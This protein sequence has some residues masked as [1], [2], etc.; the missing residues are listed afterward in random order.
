MLIVYFAQ[1]P[2][3]EEISR[4]QQLLTDDQWEHKEVGQVACTYEEE[5]RTLQEVIWRMEDET[6]AELENIFDL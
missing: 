6:K 1:C 5:A 3:A 4:L 2:A